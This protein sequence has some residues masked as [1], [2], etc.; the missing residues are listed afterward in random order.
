[1]IEAELPSPAGFAA[2]LAR[3][4]AAL[5]RARGESAIRTRRRDPSRW[6]RAALLWPLLG[7]R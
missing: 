6:R 2:R 3:K 4:A 7:P 1:M 5:A